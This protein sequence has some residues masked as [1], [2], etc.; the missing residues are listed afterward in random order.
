MSPFRNYPQFV[1]AGG[2]CR[3]SR[4]CAVCSGRPT[5]LMQEFL[6]LVRAS[7]SPE[8]IGTLAKAARSALL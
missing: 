2:Q 8:E 6:E 1:L 7:W 3:P 4:R 5:Q